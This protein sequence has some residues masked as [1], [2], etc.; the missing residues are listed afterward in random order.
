MAK[1]SKTILVTGGAGFIGSWLSKE[2]IKKGYRVIIVDNLSNGSKENI[3]S[4]AIFY[5]IDIRD[6][7]LEKIFRKEKPHS[8][9]HLAAQTNASY[10]VANP[11]LDADINILGTIHLLQ[12]SLRFKIKKF[13]FAS[14]AAVYGNNKHLP[15]KENEMLSP[16]SPY[17]CSKM[18]AEN[19]IILFN[20]LYK[21]PFIILRLSNVYGPYQKKGDNG[22]VIN[23]FCQK[24]LN[25]ERPSIYG[26]GTQSRDFIFVS[27]VITAF[28]KSITINKK[29]FI[30]NVSTNRSESV[31]HIVK[32]INNQLNKKLSPRHLPSK[33]GDIKDSVLNSS[34]AKKIL[35]WKPR[36]KIE[37]GIKETLYFLS[38]IDKI[39]K[40]PHNKK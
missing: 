16:I 10:S 5:K 21:F 23:L 17:G 2:L 38:K 4:Q 33:S 13:I 35:S 3:P 30:L 28:I 11:K 1:N 14:S 12:L 6:K 7:K 29:N 31:L 24:M 26:S 32:I 40:I 8:V 34:K 25:D 15:L 22:G 39:K 18:S 20:K 9:I 19:Y 37:K 36:V 27:D